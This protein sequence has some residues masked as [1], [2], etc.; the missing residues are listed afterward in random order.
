M[1]KGVFFSARFKHLKESMHRVFKR[2]HIG[3]LVI[4]IRT[5]TP[6]KNE[7]TVEKRG[8]KFSV[9]QT[10][11][12]EA[13]MDERF[14]SSTP[15]VNLLQFRSYLSLNFLTITFLGLVWSEHSVL[16]AHHSTITLPVR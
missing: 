11:L 5:P 3:A 15:L 13:R 16:P 9:F 6:K 7:K 12:H 4:L 14:E 1:V 2:F 10:N 8:M